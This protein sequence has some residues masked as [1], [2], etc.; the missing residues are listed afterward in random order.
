MIPNRFRFV[1]G[2]LEISI[3]IMCLMWSNLNW[4]VGNGM[5]PTHVLN[6]K[7]ITNLSFDSKNNHLL[8]VFGLLRILVRGAFLLPFLP[9][10]RF[11]E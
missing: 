7:N 10:P 8:I 9:H 2:A 3:Y 11:L 1:M 6:L 5:H 4:A